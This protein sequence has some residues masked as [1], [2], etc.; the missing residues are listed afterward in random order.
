MSFIGVLN[1]IPLFYNGK[2]SNTLWTFFWNSDNGVPHPPTKAT[3]IAGCIAIPLLQ[4][5]INASEGHQFRD[6]SYIAI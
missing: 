2:I 3:Y 5:G 4:T 1:H 6:P